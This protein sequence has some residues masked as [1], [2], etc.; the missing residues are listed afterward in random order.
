MAEAYKAYEAK[1]YAKALP[2]FIAAYNKLGIVTQDN[3]TYVKR[4]MGLPFLAVM[5]GRM[6]LLGQGTDRD[7][8]KAIEW[9]K[10]AALQTYDPT[11]VKDGAAT[12]PEFLSSQAEAAMVL[13]E[14]YATGF[15]VPVDKA[16][17]RRWYIRATELEYYPAFQICGLIFESGYGGPADPAKAVDYFTQAAKAGYVPSQYT[18]GELYYLGEDG[19]KQDKTVAGAWLLKA[20][21]GGYPDAL[22]AV[23]RMYDLGE[24]GAT[25]DPAKA[26]IYYKEAAVKG[27]PD[28]EE[29][30]GLSF[31]T[32]NGLAKDPATA[33]QWFE[34]AA[35]NA[36]VDAMFNLAV[37]LING[38]GGDRDLVKAWV[39]LKIA[40][41]GGH[42]RAQAAL[43]ELEPKMT[44]D[45]R[46]RAQALFQPA[47]K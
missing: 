13:A 42:P 20:A 39:W 11:Q 28:A 18:V 36:N 22:Y 45:E 21:K 4:V 15:G 27:Q 32:G 34:K 44:P 40:V 8:P 37:M 24:G 10:K 16:E 31:Y 30:I 12:K 33:R 17:A 41:A 25:V 14:I 47:G 1:D 9:F 23:G 3:P 26:L 19:V 5:V 35:E 2:L 46:A 6:Y 38:E 7:M 29:A 43:A